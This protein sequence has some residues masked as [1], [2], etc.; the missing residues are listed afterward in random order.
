MVN[1]IIIHGSPIRDKRK[2]KDYVLEIE[3]HWL[4][5]LKEELEKQDVETFIPAMPEPWKPKYEEWKKEFEKLRSEVNKNTILIGHSAGGAFLARWLGETEREVKKLILVAAGKIIRE[6]SQ[7]RLKELY[8]FDIDKNIKNNVEEIVVFISDDELEHRKES[9]RIYEKE[10]EARLI[11]M[12][13]MGH[14]V[15]K[16]MGTHEFPELLE[17]VLK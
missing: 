4:L 1:C 11:E 14:F 13:N 17:E 9:A 6:A 10:L 5:W 2:D 7:D 8:T 3:K 12:K 15:M 16:D